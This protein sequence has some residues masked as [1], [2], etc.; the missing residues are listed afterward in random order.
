[1]AA[2][3]VLFIGWNRAR[4]GQEKVCVELFAQSMA[5]FA[6]EQADGHIE[7]FEPV[8][9]GAHGGQVNGFT[10]LRGEQSKIDKLRASDAFLDLMTKLN[11]NVDGLSVLGGWTGDGVA[12][13]MARLQKALG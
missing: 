1:M 10:L 9:L 13:Q 3:T 8:F 7:G 5:Y 6:K 12:R 4:P 2:D 11:I